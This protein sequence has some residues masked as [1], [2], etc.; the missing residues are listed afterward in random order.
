MKDMYEVV[1][2]VD[3][4]SN[5]GKSFGTVLFDTFNEAE[6]FASCFESLRSD[7][8]AFVTRKEGNTNE[9]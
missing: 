3:P 6:E 5:D 1:T 7:T 2:F 8:Y 4:N 9:L